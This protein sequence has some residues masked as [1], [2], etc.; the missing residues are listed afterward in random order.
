MELVICGDYLKLFLELVNHGDYFKTI[1]G[2][3]EVIY[4]NG[5]L[6]IHEERLETIYGV[7]H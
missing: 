7:S 3:L 1:Y 6:T 5:H 2:I 4:E